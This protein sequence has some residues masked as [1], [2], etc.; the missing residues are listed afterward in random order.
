MYS[1]VYL[2]ARYVAPFVVLLWIGVFSG[3]RL[4]NSQECRRLA[5]AVPIALV[6]IMGIHFWPPAYAAV[7]GD[8]PPQKHGVWELSDRLH[9]IGVAPG[10]KVAR[11]GYGASA[12]WAHL[13]R[14]QI[15]GEMFA[16]REDF[17]SVVNVERI[18]LEDGSLEPEAIKAFAS[19]GATAIIAQRV[20][21]AVSRNGWRELGYDYYAYILPK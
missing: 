20:P 19:T 10:D 15:V 21:L 6:I 12:Y 9:Q 17:S 5:L 16:E 7:R 8:L 18:L 1:F 13:A 11:I 2:S 14:V 4:P 3:V